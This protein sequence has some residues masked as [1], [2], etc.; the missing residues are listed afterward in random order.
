M[1][2]GDISNEMQ[3]RVVVVWENLLGQLDPLLV[4]KEQ[5]LLR[6]HR[7]KAAAELWEDNHIG[8]RAFTD[9]TWRKGFPVD[10][11]ITHHAM[12]AD[13]I[14]QRMEAANRPFGNV[15][16]DNHE[17]FEFRLAFMPEIAVVIHGEQR[18]QFLYGSRGRMVQAL[19]E[20]V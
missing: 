17:D 15:Y 6:R 2:G 9:M 12:F 13:Y 3:S 7:Y 19:S 8:W 1:Q 16:L 11:L 14:V 18:R 10:V 20:V 5:K 4:A